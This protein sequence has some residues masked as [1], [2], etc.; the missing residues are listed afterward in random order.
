MSA[1]MYDRNP[2]ISSPYDHSLDKS[3]SLNESMAECAASR[4]YRTMMVTANEILSLEPLKRGFDKS[5]S[6]KSTGK[7]GTLNHREYLR[8]SPAVNQNVFDNLKDLKGKSF[9][10]VHYMDTHEPYFATTEFLSRLG[11]AF[12]SEVFTT[13]I[14][15]FLR[16]GRTFLPHVYTAWDP[17]EKK[18]AEQTGYTVDEAISILKDH[19]DASVCSTDRSFKE[20]FDRLKKQGLLED[21]LLVFS[22]DHGENLSD[23]KERKLRTVGHAENLTQQAIHSPLFVYHPGFSFKGTAVPQPVSSSRI[24]NRLIRGFMSGRDLDAL[25]REEDSANNEAIISALNIKTGGTCFNGLAYTQGNVKVALEI[26]EDGTQE[27][28][29]F[30]TSKDEV[31]EVTGNTGEWIAKAEKAL[32]GKELAAF[33]LDSLSPEKRE[34][35]NALGYLN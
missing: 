8:S 16:K 20:L 34:Q 28:K 7:P 24:A 18:L 12:N 3:D 13:R 22:S 23:D 26:N 27:T 14:R 11:A 10:Y 4:G 5:I 25:I 2:L 32:E 21:T 1:I 30:N 17:E 19:Y 9:L 6:L 15:G 33:S 35:L 29:V 31:A